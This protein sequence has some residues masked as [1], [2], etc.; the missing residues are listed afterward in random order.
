MARMCKQKKGGA[1]MKRIKVRLRV[2]PNAKKGG[3]NKIVDFI[4][5][6]ALLARLLLLLSG[7]L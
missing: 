3:I 7:Q 2:R 5:G 1:K 6:L 4:L